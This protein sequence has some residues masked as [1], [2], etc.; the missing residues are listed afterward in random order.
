M[1]EPSIEIFG[2]QHFH[3]RS[4]KFERQ[5]KRVKSAANRR[6][7]AR[8]GGGQA[9]LRLDISNSL[10]EQLHGGDACKIRRREQI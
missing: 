1:L 4:R 9:K 7:G 2:W 3:P 6:D 5:W 10:N 8:V